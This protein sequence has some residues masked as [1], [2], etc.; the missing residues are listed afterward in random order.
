[1]IDF[2]KGFSITTI[3][4]MHL[5]QDN[6]TLLPRILHIVSSIGG[7]GVHV[8]IF[9]SGFGLYLSHL[10][11]PKSYFSFL[12]ARMNKLYIPYILVVFIAFLI[13]VTY[14]GENRVIALLSH[15]FLFKMFVP[16]FEGSFCGQL[17]FMSTII[18]FYLVFIPL[19]SLKKALKK[20][21]NFMAVT[22]FISVCYWIML[23]LINKTDIRVWSSF[24]LQYLWEFCFGMVC[25]EKFF[26]GEKINL[27]HSLLLVISVVG[28]G[29]QA[30]M[31][32]SSG[33]L[34]VF[35]DIPALF[36]YGSLALLIYSVGFM[37]KIILF[38]SKFSYEWYL[39]HMLIFTLIYLL[40]PSTLAGQVILGIFALILS[41]FIALGYQ[42]LLK[43]FLKK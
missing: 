35:N 41:V 23:L 27:S 7:T 6:I 19:C 33:V 20:T 2:L 37:N 40:A 24:F 8:F 5:M 31:A 12:L 32:L 3:V 28:I 43:K 29:C 14:T 10:H 17:W 13:P 39:T 42:K 9:C 25:A 26:K 22:L 15:I 1:M 34:K 38:L 16:E 36:G 11:K 4:I 30:F 18:Q 21:S